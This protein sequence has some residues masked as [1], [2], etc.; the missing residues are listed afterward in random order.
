[1]PYRLPLEIGPSGFATMV[2]AVMALAGLALGAAA[3]RL[4]RWL[5]VDAGSGASPK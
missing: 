2:V 3:E 4:F 5:G 1:M